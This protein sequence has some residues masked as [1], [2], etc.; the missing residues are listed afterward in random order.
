[1]KSCIKWIACLLACCVTGASS[2]DT[3]FGDRD[4][5]ATWYR[6]AIERMERLDRKEWELIWQFQSDRS[7]EP[8]PEL[9]AVLAKAQPIIDLFRRGST[10]PWSDFALD[11]FQ[12]LTTPGPQ[13]ALQQVVSLAQVDAIVRL[14]DGHTTD[15]AQRIAATYRAADQPWADEHASGPSTRF[16]FFSWMDVAAQH[17]FDRGSFTVHDSELMLKALRG[18]DGPDPFNFV[19][20]LAGRQEKMLNVLR[21]GGDEQMRQSLPDWL[22]NEPGQRE[23]LLAMTEDEFAVQAGQCEVLMDR[24]ASAFAMDDREAARADLEKISTEIAAGE[25]G[26]LAQ[27]ITMSPLTLFDLNVRL[28]KRVQERLDMLRKITEGELDPAG[29]ANA[30]T[31][32]WRAI[33]MLGEI[34]LEQ[35][36]AACA[37]TVEGDEPIA[38]EV[39][40]V[41]EKAEP[42]I[43]VLRE[44]SRKRRCDFSVLRAGLRWKQFCPK[45]DPGLWVAL[46]LLRADAA[47]LLRNEKRQEAVD[48]LTIAYRIIAHLSDDDRIMSALVAHQAFMATHGF[49]LAA[50]QGDRLGEAERAALLSTVRQIDRADP[51]GYLR[52]IRTTREDL[53]LRCDHP[54]AEESGF[55]VELAT[56]LRRLDGDC[57]LYALAV[58]DTIGPRGV[59]EPPRGEDEPEPLQSPQRL[60]DILSFQALMIARGQ[61]PGVEPVLARGEVDVLMREDLPCI[62][63]VVERQRAARSD[64]RKAMKALQDLAADGDD[65]VDAPP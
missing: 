55:Q 15:A 49:S 46:R 57:L 33:E 3:D 27:S 12:S 7:Q 16:R 43:D 17:G 21:P 32:Y 47:R 39:L 22:F 9:R 1:M 34:P 60:K 14:H 35:L 10:R 13:Q 59:V 41:F 19:G 2:A 31:Y 65:S 36:E 40:R 44:G 30:A 26:L 29:E 51:F 18:L 23:Q 54:R 25:F 6:R 50:L 37:V 38:E 11:D 42:A 20:G 8:S 5:A 28:E 53:A 4:N 52:A 62:G 48:R 45:Y 64:L 58:H 56:R 61:A 63:Q 24:I